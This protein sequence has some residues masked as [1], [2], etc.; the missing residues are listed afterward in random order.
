MR[1]FIASLATALV[2]TIG[3]VGVGMFNSREVPSE[4]VSAILSLLGIY[5]FILG[6]TAC[7]A[8]PF[9]LL[10]RRWDFARSWVS[11]AIGAAVGIFAVASFEYVLTHVPALSSPNHH[12]ALYMYIQF[13]VV[14]VAGGLVFWRYAQSE[15]RPNK[16][17]ERT[18]EG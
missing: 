4:P 12:V 8:V 14:G 13:A 10:A 17:L 1:T 2:V 9:R 7:I 5:L 3:L 15:L 18:R 16:S 6:V 11:A